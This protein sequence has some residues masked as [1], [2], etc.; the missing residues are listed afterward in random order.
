MLLLQQWL[1]SYFLGTR[2][3]VKT[4]NPLHHLEIMSSNE[5]YSSLC[6]LQV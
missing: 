4:I 2:K 1:M 6:D 5:V 3:S